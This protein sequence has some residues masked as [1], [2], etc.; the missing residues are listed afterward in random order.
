VE[1]RAFRLYAGQ[2]VRWDNFVAIDSNSVSA[3]PVLAY[4]DY[5]PFGLVMGGRSWNWGTADARYTYTEK[6]RVGRIV[7]TTTTSDMVSLRD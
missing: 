4:D 2:N 6:E 7:G 1:K 3:G 5:Y